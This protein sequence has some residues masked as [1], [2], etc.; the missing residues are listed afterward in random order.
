ME[1]GE[2][3]SEGGETLA[4]MTREWERAE[5]STRPPEW[6]TQREKPRVTEW[7]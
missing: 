2:G 7:S 1:I 3:K 5:E 6:K 4:P